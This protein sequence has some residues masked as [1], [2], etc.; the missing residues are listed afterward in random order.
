MFDALDSHVS[1]DAGTAKDIEHNNNM[2]REDQMIT[3]TGDLVT[4]RGQC[5]AKGLDV[6]V[7][8]GSSLLVTGPNGCGK[9]SFFR[10]LAGLWP[11][12]HG[13]VERPQV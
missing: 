11:P 5:L 4:P 1:H 9:T 12:Q 8:P 3:A 2:I 7:V 13:H 10:L 6:A